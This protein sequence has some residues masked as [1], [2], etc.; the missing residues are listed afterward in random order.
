MFTFLAT[1]RVRALELFGREW[2]RLCCAARF[3]VCR[4]LP[5]LFDGILE[6]RTIVGLARFEQNIDQVGH[7]SRHP[8]E[9]LT[10][11][12][13]AAGAALMIGLCDRIVANGCP[14][15]QIEGALEAMIAIMSR[16]VTIAA[17]AAGYRDQ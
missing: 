1:A 17:T 7:S 16:P 5:A 9:R 2:T 12:K 15:S 11:I 10:I 6:D 8:L 14:R 4:L 13:A 3:C